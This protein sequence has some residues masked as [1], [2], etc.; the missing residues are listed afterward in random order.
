MRIYRDSFEKS[1][2][3]GNNS[4]LIRRELFQALW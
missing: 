4:K 3:K 2:K 1:S